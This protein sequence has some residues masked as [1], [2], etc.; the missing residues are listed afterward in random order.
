[1]TLSNVKMTLYFFGCWFKRWWTLIKPGNT[2]TF[3][4]HTLFD[5]LKSFVHTLMNIFD[6]FVSDR[7]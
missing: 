4:I 3:R 5:A 7:S 2:D 6:K 1:M